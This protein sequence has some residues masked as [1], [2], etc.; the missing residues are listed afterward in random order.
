MNKRPKGQSSFKQSA[1]TFIEQE[2]LD[3][4]QLLKFEML[5]TSQEVEITTDSSSEE[6][7]ISSPVT[8]RGGRAWYGLSALAASLVLVFMLSVNYLSPVPDLSLQI[9]E[10]VAMNHIKM[11]PLELRTD[12]IKPLRDYFT[13]LDF[14]VVGS[15]IISQQNINMLGGR[16]C[17]IQGVSAAQI[18]YETDT[19]QRVTLYEVGYDVQRY[20]DIPQLELGEAP[21]SLDVKGIN[22]SIWVEK[23]LLMA[24][25]KS[26]E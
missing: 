15:S 23:G 3:E 25:V 26:I 24:A 12:K 18:R 10:E 19:G 4:E 16:Y 5:L 14:S 22:V 6:Q 2:S 7:V 17:S 13:E 11:K 8:K 20:G 9:A 21:L 1:K